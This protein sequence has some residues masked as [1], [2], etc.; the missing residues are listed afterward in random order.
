MNDRYESIATA[1]DNTFL[2]VYEDPEK[3]DR[4]WSNF[5]EWL[6]SGSNIYWIQGKAASGK[7][8]LMRFIWNNPSTLMYLKNWSG[9]SK[10][11]V[12][13][14]FFWNRGI[15]EQRSQIGLLRSL[16]YVA[17]KARKVIIAD[18]FPDEWENKSALAAHDLPISPEVWSL[19][20]L[21]RAFRDFIGLASRQLK[22][23]FFIDGLDE[24]EGGAE[25]IAQYFK[26]LSLLSNHAK[27][28]LSSRPWPI[29]QAALRMLWIKT[30][31]PDTERHQ[32]LCS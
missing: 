31:G 28:C 27:F 11:V 23:C 18:V 5:A 15:Q 3:F 14:F 8:T 10:T 6:S 30:A 17:L 20:R 32:D 25:D 2:W 26:E 1:Y 7:S 4:P 9:G 19:G 24:Y 12:A 21:K 13:A 16:L 22:L 29:F